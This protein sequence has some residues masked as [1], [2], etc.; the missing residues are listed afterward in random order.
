MG[1][2]VPRG[3]KKKH[4]DLEIQFQT[5]L[6]AGIQMLLLIS[7]LNLAETGGTVSQLATVTAVGEEQRNHL[8]DWL[9]KCLIILHLRVG[10]DFLTPWYK[11]VALQSMQKH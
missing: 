1:D 8:R 11:T 4:E 2:I 7:F 10:P 6:Q 5:P 9:L 3:K